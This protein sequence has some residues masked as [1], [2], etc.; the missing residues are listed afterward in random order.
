ME[1]RTKGHRMDGHE[2]VLGE[3]EHDHFEKVAG[4]VGAEDQ[5]L[6][7][8]AVGIEIDH[9]KRVVRRRYPWSSSNAC[10]DPA[11]VAWSSSH[12]DAVEPAQFLAQRVIG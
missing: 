10:R 4:T 5:E 6:R 7:R 2:S 11:V 1:R 8:I 3:F 12:V 9:H